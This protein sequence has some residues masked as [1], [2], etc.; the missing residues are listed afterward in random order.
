[1]SGWTELRD[2]GAVFRPFD[3]LTF[4]KVQRA[5]EVLGA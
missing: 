3:G 1:M 5:R 2:L 4:R